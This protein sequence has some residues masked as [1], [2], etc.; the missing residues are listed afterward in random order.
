MINPMAEWWLHRFLLLLALPAAGACSSDPA[1]PASCLE[2]G[3]VRQALSAG[4]LQQSL[5][6]ISAEDDPNYGRV[7]CQV[8]A[9]W[10]DGLPD[11]K[12]RL[13][14]YPSDPRFNI[15]AIISCL[16]AP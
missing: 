3:T 4:C 13:S 16:G 12:Q 7:S 14:F 6:P 2:L 5:D 1:Q 8:L 15:T 9:G 11:N 10:S